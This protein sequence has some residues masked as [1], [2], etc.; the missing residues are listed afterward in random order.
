MNQTNKEYLNALKKLYKSKNII[1]PRGKNT[2]E[3]IGYLFKFNS[4]Q[5][6]LI[7]IP[8]FKTNEKYAHEEYLWYLNAGNNINFS[9]TIKNTWEKFS[10]DGI[11]V[12]SA[13][14]HRIFGNHENININQWEWIKKK[15]EKDINSRQCIININLPSDKYKETLDF[16]CTIYCQ[17]FVRENKL[18]WIT[19]MRS[20]DIYYGTR[21]DIYCFMSFQELLAKELKILCGNYYHFCGS[22]HIYEKQFEKLEKLFK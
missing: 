21:N 8:E 9:Q 15:L 13:Y 7:T 11:H 1:N 5:N 16:P 4:P 19:N 18:I 12:N 3:L 17:I 2:K 14:G 10:D 22:L 6:K 20:Q